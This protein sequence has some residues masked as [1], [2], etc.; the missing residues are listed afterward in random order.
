V[1]SL[2]SIADAINDWSRKWRLSNELMYDYEGSKNNN[3]KETS[4]GEE[5]DDSRTTMSSKRNKAL[6]KKATLREK[7]KQLLKKGKKSRQRQ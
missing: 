6:D 3:K 7:F 4:M 2:L 5:D 1:K